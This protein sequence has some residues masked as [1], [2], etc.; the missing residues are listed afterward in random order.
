MLTRFFHVDVF[1]AEPFSGNPAVVCPLEG[2][3]D[4]TWMQNVAAEMNVSETAFLHLEANGFHLLWF[5]PTI[6]VDLCGHAMLAN[7]HVLWEQGMLDAATPARFHTLSG[8]LTVSTSGDWHHMDFP[9]ELA[10]ATEAPP[11]L[12]DS[13]GA[14]VGYVG[15]KQA[16]L[17]RR[18]G[19]RR[20]D[21]Q[22]VA[23]PE[24]H[25][26]APWPWRRRDRESG[27][28]RRRLRVTRVRTGRGHPRGPRHRFGAVRARPLLARTARQE[29]ARRAS[30][31]DAGRAD[32]GQAAGDRVM[33]SGLAAT[34]SEGVFTASSSAS[35]RP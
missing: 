35:I 22:A 24:R 11:E 29:R 33:V 19:V 30:D 4:A 23:R 14:P 21:S 12:A 6:E 26:Q 1:T 28:A 13:L 17:R 9:A 10:V 27:Y 34:T 8:L 3:A 18:A 20:G 16:R 15:Q 2:P 31:V 25:R 5:T 7:A 32:Q